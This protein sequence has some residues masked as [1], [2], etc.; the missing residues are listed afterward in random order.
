[1]QD[2]P[3]PYDFCKVDGHAF[4]TCIERDHYLWEKEEY[5]RK[6]RA[7]KIRLDNREWEKGN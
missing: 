6:Q 5:A 4:G 2:E 3:G 1:V 7:E